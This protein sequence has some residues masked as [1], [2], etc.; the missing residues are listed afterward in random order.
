VT[1]GITLW[2]LLYPI[3]IITIVEIRTVNPALPAVIDAV[4]EG[5]IPN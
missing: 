5:I 4:L 2:I 3:I 1:H